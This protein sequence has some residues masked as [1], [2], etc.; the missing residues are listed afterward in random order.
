MN[1][2]IKQAIDYVNSN[3]PKEQL[4]PFG[5]NDAIDHLKDDELRHTKM[6]E[7]MA[8]DAKELLQP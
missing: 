3:T 6:A 2:G 7:A 8:Q 5:G 4:S 1:K